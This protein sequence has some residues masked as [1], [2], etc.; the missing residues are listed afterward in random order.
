MHTS[1]DCNDRT[2]K[3]V[4]CR[5]NI[6]LTNTFICKLVMQEGCDMVRMPTYINSREMSHLC[7]LFNHT[8]LR[9]NLWHFLLRLLNTD[10]TVE[11]GREGAE[12]TVFKTRRGSLS[13]KRMQH[14]G[15][16]WLLLSCPLIHMQLFKT[17]AQT[18][19]NLNTGKIQKQVVGRGHSKALLTHWCSYR[20]QN[21]VELQYV[22]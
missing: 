13:A 17:R 1:F 5:S 15:K 14:P 6:T 3:C 18:H 7:C 10:H 20:W 11:E 12:Y 16:G 4:A 22:D 21:K 2:N 8:E 19:T 9:G